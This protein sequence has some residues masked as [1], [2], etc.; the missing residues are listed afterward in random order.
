VATACLPRVFL[1]LNLSLF[2]SFLSV[3][4]SE[5][6]LRVAVYCPAAA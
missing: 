5:F 3:F 1:S 4:A 6:R 2:G